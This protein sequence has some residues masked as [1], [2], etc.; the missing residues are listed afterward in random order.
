MTDPVSSHAPEL[1]YGTID[2]QFGV[3]CEHRADGGLTVTI[4]STIWRYMLRRLPPHPVVLPILLGWYVIERLLNRQLPPHAVIELTS[5]HL[6]ITQ[7]DSEGT[8]KLTTRTWP[9][10]QVGEVRPNRYAR[11][12]YIRIPGKENFDMLGDVDQR[13]VKHVGERLSEALQRVRSKPRGVA[14]GLG[15]S[16]MTF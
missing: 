4:P 16:S 10:D 2:T 15:R 6:S 14:D 13:L 3:T 1:S 7:P 8:R 5:E 9:L 11:G 12:L